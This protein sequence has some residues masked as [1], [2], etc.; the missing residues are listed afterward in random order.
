MRELVPNMN[1]REMQAANKTS[2]K[3]VFIEQ[4]SVLYIQCHCH[5]RKRRARA[6]GVDAEL[7]EDADEADDPKAAVVAL[8]VEEEGKKLPSV[9]Q[10]AL[11]EELGKLKLGALKRTVVDTTNPRQGIKHPAETWQTW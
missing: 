10:A 9:S 11:E 6:S 5:H 3:P 1:N 7:L 8:I 4:D 2:I